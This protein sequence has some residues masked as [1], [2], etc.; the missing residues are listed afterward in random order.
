M[1]RVENA[2]H[3]DPHVSKAESDFWLSPEIGAR[4]AKDAQPFFQNAQSIAAPYIKAGKCHTFS[5]SDVLG[6]GI[7]II[8][9]HGHTPGHTGY[10]DHAA[11]AAM[12]NP[13]L[14]TLAREGT[15][16]AGPHMPF[17]GVGRLRK[18]ANGYVSVIFTDQWAER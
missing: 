8:S 7:K 6:D 17:P 16:I 2:L 12:R 11:A 13:L 5:D 10:I 3:E 18:E 14:P 15:M 1:D 4:A 9:L